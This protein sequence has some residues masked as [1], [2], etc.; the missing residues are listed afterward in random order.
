MMKRILV[1][2][3]FLLAIPSL[4]YGAN[5]TKIGVLPFN[6][7]SQEN[8]DYLK[9]GV[10]R[11]LNSQFLDQGFEIAS[12]TDVQDA[13]KSSG[14]EFPDPR[15]AQRLGKTLKTDYIVYGSLT[16]IGNS[17]S[18]DIRIVDTLGIKKTASVYVQSEG[19]ET[20][21]GLIQKLAAEIAVRVSREKRIARIFIIGNER[22]EPDAIRAVIEAR[23]GALFS[24]EGISSDLRRIYATNYFKDVKVDVEESEKGKIVKFIVEEKPSIQ[25]IEFKGLSAKKEEDLLEILG[26]RL[27]SIVDTRKVLASVENIKEEYRKDGY[28][29][30]EISHE[31][32]DIDSKRVSIRYNVKEKNRIYIEEIAFV[33]NDNIDRKEL[34]DLMTTREKGFFYWLTDSG[35][36]KQDDLRQDVNKLVAYYHNNG[37][38]KAQVSDP[39]VTVKQDRLI[40][41]ITIEEGPQYKMDK[42]SFSGDLIRPV[43]EIAEQV[44]IKTGDVFNRDVIQKDMQAISK[45]YASQGYAYAF[46]APLIQENNDTLSV[47]IEYKI[48]K[49]RLVYFERID[50][51]GNTKTR[52]NVIRR[53]L[54]VHEG[55][56]FSA[57]NISLSLLNLQRLGYFEDMDISQSRGSSED[58]MNIKIDLKEQSTASFGAGLGYSSFNKLFGTVRISDD[59]LFGRGQRLQ[60]QGSLGSRI[61]EYSLSFTEP[62]LMGI[63]LSAGFNVYDQLYQYDNYD[64]DSI[65]FGL[66][67]GYPVRDFVRLSLGY[68][69]E[70]AEV[71]NIPDTASDSIKQSAG[72]HIT[73]GM[74]VTLRRDTRNRRFNP[75]EGSDTS[76]NVEYVGGLLGGTSDFTRYILN[77]G[78]FF[79]LPWGENHVF[80]TRGKIGFVNRTSGGN[81]PIFERFYLGGL[82][83]IRG[84][85]WGRVGPRDPVT[86]E[87]IGAE[88]II[89][90]NFEYIFPILKDFGLTGVLFFDT[91]DAYSENENIDLTTFRKSIGAGLRYYSPFGPLRLEWGYVLDPRPGEERGIWE[92]T[93]GSFF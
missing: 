59:N 44:T 11:L 15:S 50:I 43:E 48:T 64:K 21:T 77:S 46:V 13:M 8:L 51:T 53:E 47:D 93:M 87:L 63:P 5:S 70:S 35:I 55:D 40:V 54:K 68:R 89:F 34:L 6:V 92:F 65:G 73:S 52:E 20:L 66:R 91:G 38:I 4:V 90:F 79:P 3:F 39:E 81:L 27:Y 62:W 37:Y 28:Y 45:M 2:L 14:V 86:G 58:K 10:A 56:L 78:W 22:I 60:L 74:S 49:N 17:I 57:E 85:R 30:A 19:L 25:S 18:L 12:K 31:I 80:F 1:I 82:D 24:E 42:I 75:T 16:K 69:Y 84:F 23:E 83:S 72:K 76:I 29:N 32:R 61:T 41:T 9:D 36:L 33:G 26:Y 7:F 88:K 67:F 71:K